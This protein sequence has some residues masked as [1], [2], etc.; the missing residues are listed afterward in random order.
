MYTQAYFKWADCPYNVS[1]LSFAGMI[2]V[3]IGHSDRIA[4][5]VTNVQSDVMDLYHPRLYCYCL[6]TTRCY[7]TQRTL[8]KI[9]LSH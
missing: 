9:R 1:G 5:G 7:G 4:W 8:Q 3:I 2:G 6:N